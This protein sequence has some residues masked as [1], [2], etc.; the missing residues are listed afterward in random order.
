MAAADGWRGVI[1]ETDAT[2]E[3]DARVEVADVGDTESWAEVG[4]NRLLPTG[5]DSSF[6]VELPKN[7]VMCGWFFVVVAD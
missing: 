4:C 6:D 7:D 5:F 2:F 3:E 1:V